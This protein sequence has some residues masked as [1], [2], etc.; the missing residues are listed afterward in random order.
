M[1]RGNYE[2]VPGCGLG[3]HKYYDYCYD[4]NYGNAN[5]LPIAKYVGN[6]NF[7]SGTLGMC[8]GDCDNDSHCQVSMQRHRAWY[9]FLQ[10]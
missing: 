9:T 5:P 2:P 8:E 10:S 3:G 1:Q 6:K 7:A 4:L